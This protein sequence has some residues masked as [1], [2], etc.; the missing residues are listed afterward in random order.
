LAKIAKQQRRAVRRK[1]VAMRER[2][3]QRAPAWASRTVGPA[4]DWLDMLLVD[5]GVFRMLYPNRF[6]LGAQA[7][8]SSQPTP[9]QIGWAARHGIRTIV[10]LRGERDCGSFRLQQEACLRHGLALEE[11][12]VRS[13]AAPTR[14]QV[15]E[16]KA[17]FERIAYPVL[18]HCKSGADRA[19]LASVLYLVL[20]E[21]WPVEE[22]VDQLHWRFG[23]FK[24]ADTGIIDLFFARYLEHA[25]HEPMD[26]LTWVDRVYDP[27]ALA[28]DFKASR[29]G[30]LLV[31]KILRRE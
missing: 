19:G 21:G 7:W 16:A 20:R 8:R 17:L 22:A 11:L 12:V 26:F 28:G 5:H 15:H 3:D 30:N 29:W 24:A 4:I 1:V 27:A 18:L 31:D 25:S 9:H 23:H 13:R 6:R 10:N 2:L 14:E